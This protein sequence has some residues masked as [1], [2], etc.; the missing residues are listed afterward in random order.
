MNFTFDVF[1][2]YSS[3]DSNWVHDVLK[4]RLLARGFTVLTDQDFKGGSLSIDEMA[5]AIEFSRRTLAVMTQSF[6][7]SKWTQLETSMAQTL[8]PD[9]SERKL[10]PVLIEDCKIPLRLRIL[11]YRDLRNGGQWDQLIQD[12]I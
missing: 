4:P 8:D 12:L 6:V 5:K 7:E 9:A 10:V 3:K 11:H 1:I 2:S